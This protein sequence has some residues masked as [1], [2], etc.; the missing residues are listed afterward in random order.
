MPHHVLGSAVLSPYRHFG[1]QPSRTPRPAHQIVGQEAELFRRFQ[2]FENS[3]LVWIH[4]RNLRSFGHSTP[5]AG[6]GCTAK[7]VPRV[8]ALMQRFLET[9]RLQLNPS[10]VMPRN[11]VKL[12]QTA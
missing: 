12:A 11:A 1:A 3:V 7:F 4:A 9:R 6:F 2:A 10:T 5:H 8:V